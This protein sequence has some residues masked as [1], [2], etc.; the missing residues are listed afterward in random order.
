MSDTTWVNI[1]IF[2]IF[3]LYFLHLLW[4]WAKQA[5]C[6]YCHDNIPLLHSKADPYIEVKINEYLPELELE[7]E[8]Y[9]GTKDLNYCPMCARRL[10]QIMRR[11]YKYLIVGGVVVGLL[12]IGSIVIPVHSEIIE[13]KTIHVS[14][15]T[16]VKVDH[17][18]ADLR[19]EG[20]ETDWDTSYDPF[21]ISSIQ[22]AYYDNQDNYIADASLND[23]IHAQSVISGKQYYS[24][25]KHNYTE[26]I[27]QYTNL[28]HYSWKSKS[29]DDKDT[30][31]LVDDSSY[32]LPILLH[33]NGHY[34]LGKYN[35]SWEKDYKLTP[36]D[37]KYVWSEDN[38]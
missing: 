6:A 13:T 35:H 26:K 18:E 10:R 24:V 28:Y 2:V 22:A 4:V 1:S 32:N 36:K 33:I 29:N 34:R 8:I 3:L 25:T 11:S 23:D 15:S 27:T 17:I 21:N 30:S 5:N 20:T 9:Y 14:N 16:P 7:S 38:D 37:G 12:G 31:K 19:Y